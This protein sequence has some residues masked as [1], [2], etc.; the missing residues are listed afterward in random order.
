MSRRRSRRRRRIPNKRNRRSKRKLILLILALIAVLAVIIV[1]HRNETE[2]NRISA[3]EIPDYID[4]QLLD[5][6][7]Y[8]RPGIALNKVNGIVVHYTANQ[9]STAQE[10]RDYFNGLA[11]SHETH[12][13]AH[14]VIGLDGE[15]IQ[16]IPT[17][18]IAYCSNNRNADTISIECCYRNKDGSFTRKT[19][20][21]LVSLTA[22]LCDRFHL[23]S[24]QVIRHYD[25]T[26]KMCPVYYVN[27]PDKWKKFKRDVE[28]AM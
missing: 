20:R 9:G 7:P 24:D 21:S 14:F 3:T 4:V 25:V 15:V 8:S 26:G 1:I 28:Q 17:A 11:Q 19:Y 10:N 18:E 6:N 5:V 12:A 13:S 27:H 23:S 2:E 22:W 16:C